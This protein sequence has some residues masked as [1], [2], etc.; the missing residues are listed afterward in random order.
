[1]NIKSLVTL[2]ALCLSVFVTC[3]VHAQFGGLL[4]G[5]KSGSVSPDEMEKNFRGFISGANRFS[6]V[7]GEALQLNEL[8]TAAGEKAECTKT[9]SCGLK[10][11]TALLKGQSEQLI[12]KLAELE[13]QGVKLSEA[14]TSKY[15]PAFEGFATFTGYAVKISKDSKNMEKGMKTVTLLASVP[16]VANSAI[17]IMNVAVAFQKYLTY[18]GVSADAIAKEVLA[19]QTELKGFGV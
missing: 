2:A 13:A 18:S 19:A 1:M 6:R 16:D 4:G 8:A 15:L 14:D 7:M 10:D 5:G 12:K 9:G 3:P 17:A 11:G